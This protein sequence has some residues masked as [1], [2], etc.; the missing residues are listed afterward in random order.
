LAVALLSVLLC[1]PDLAL[2]YPQ[3]SRLARVQAAGTLRVAV[4]VDPGIDHAAFQDMHHALLR[5]FANRLD[6]TLSLVEADSQ[7]A[8]LD[9][10]ARGE[11]DIA[12]PTQPVPLPLPDHL[13]AAPTYLE[14][15]TYVVCNASVA[16]P[17]LDNPSNLRKLRVSASDGYLARLS[18]SG[19]RRAGL[20][21]ASGSGTVELLEQV[22]SGGLPCTLAQGDE[23]TRASS[24]CPT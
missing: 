7:A 6:V 14:S 9:M 10:L 3:A 11:V 12:V 24:G 19:M 16:T 23:V 18:A 5:E 13:R 1:W 8:M 22:S 4:S 20:I 2:R 15:Q 21:P 17:E